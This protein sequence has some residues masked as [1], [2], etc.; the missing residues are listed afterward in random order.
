MKGQMYNRKKSCIFLLQNITYLFEHQRFFFTWKGVKSAK[1]GWSI[2]YESMD[3]L[4]HLY[5][6]VFLSELWEEINEYVI[7]RAGNTVPID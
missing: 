3:Y 7:W 1:G 4:M 2:Q 6:V 5:Y